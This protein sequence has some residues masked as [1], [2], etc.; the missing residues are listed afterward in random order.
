MDCLFI[1]EV[2]KE[3]LFCIAGIVSGSW[4]SR[5]ARQARHRADEVKLK[6]SG[7]LEFPQLGTSAAECHCLGI[8]TRYCPRA[9]NPAFKVAGWLFKAQYDRPGNG[10][11]LDT[12]G[13]HRFEICRKIVVIRMK[14]VKKWVRAVGIVVG[15]DIE[16]ETA[17]QTKTA[18]DLGPTGIAVGEGE[19]NR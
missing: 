10:I 14:G 3:V 13:F 2:G 15:I 4:L 7:Q 8:I 6:L 1:A 17:P 5:C 12:L 9:A 18:T 11:G 19:M 16:L